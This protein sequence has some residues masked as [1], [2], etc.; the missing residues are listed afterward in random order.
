MYTTSKTNYV[1][2]RCLLHSDV[3]LADFLGIHHTDAVTPAYIFNGHLQPVQVYVA[4]SGSKTSQL[5]RLFRQ[6]ADGLHYLH[7]KGMVHMELT[8][9]TVTVSYTE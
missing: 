4:S 9:S 7:S 2:F 6:I 8:S 3:Y 5:Q 1:A